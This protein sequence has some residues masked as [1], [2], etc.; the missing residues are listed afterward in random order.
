M[1]LTDNFYT[2]Q[3]ISYQQTIEQITLQTTLLSWNQSFVPCIHFRSWV[4]RPKPWDNPR[5]WGHWSKPWVHWSRPW[6][7]LPPSIHTKHEIF[8]FTFSIVFFQQTISVELQ[9]LTSYTRN[10]Q[11]V[12]TFLQTYPLRYGECFIIIYNFFLRSFFYKFL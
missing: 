3:T 10:H 1:C 12:L 2:I 7:S 9:M 11:Q 8:H 4:H 5:T 6:E